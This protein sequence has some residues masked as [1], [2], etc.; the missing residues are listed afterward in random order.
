VGGERKEQSHYMTSQSTLLKMSYGH[1]AW[2]FRNQVG[3]GWTP[4]LN[5]RD[6][7]DRKDEKS[8]SAN[9]RAEAKTFSF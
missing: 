7:D 3:S 5:P 6:T 8:P 9:P 4:T 2:K 1:G